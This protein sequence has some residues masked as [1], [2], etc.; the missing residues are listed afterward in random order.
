MNKLLKGVLWVAGIIGAGEG[1]RRLFNLTPEKYSRSW[2]ESLTVDEWGTQRE[3]VWKNYRDASLS[4]SENS[5]WER[6][7]RLF[8]DVKSEK[9]WAGRK[10]TA[11]SYPREHGHGLYK[12]D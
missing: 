8:D 7:L 3:I 6:I 5:F 4:A 11:P 1:V 9:L 10:P 12:P 2:I